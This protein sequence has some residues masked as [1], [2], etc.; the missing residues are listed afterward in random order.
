MNPLSH[1]P[2]HFATLPDGIEVLLHSVDWSR[3][4]VLVGS[5]GSVSQFDDN[6]ARK[7][8]YVPAKSV[9]K[10]ALTVDY[11]ALYQSRTLFGKDAGIKY[12]GKVSEAKELLRKEINF[13]MRKG[14]GEEKYYAFRVESWKTLPITVGV[15]FETVYKPRLTNIFLLEHCTESYELFDIKSCEQ[16]VLLHEV[17]QLLGGIYKNED[18]YEAAMQLRSGY[19]LWVHDGY[20][21]AFDN[22]GA[23]MLDNP[24]RVSDFSKNPKRVF[25]ALSE[26]LT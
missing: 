13:P 4:D 14:N 9:T 3:S 18:S 10:D 15:R 12:Y 23:R 22:G 20:L 2:S 24:I 17:K 19:S 25:S 7:Y 6:L 5:L 26:K 8:Y 11:I 21:E 16:F 1:I